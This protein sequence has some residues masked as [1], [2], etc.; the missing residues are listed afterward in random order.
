[1]KII[2]TSTIIPFVEGG[3]TFIVDW[4]EAKLKEYGHQTEVFKIPFFPF[5]KKMIPQMLSLRLLDLSA[6]S[7]KLIAIRTPSYLIKHPNKTL[8]F[9][10]HHRGAYD[11]WGTRYQDIPNTEEGIDIRNAIIKSD[12]MAFKESK[13]IYTNSKIVS[14]RL[15]KFN[16]IDSE[17]LYP[18][19]MDAEKHSCKMYGD[20]IFYPSRITSHKRQHLVMEA[21]KYV[22]SNVKLI[23]AGSPDTK[24][25]EALIKKSIRRI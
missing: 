12:N 25:D 10:H 20:Y 23:L 9:I 6:S 16:N 7:D 13:K 22:K 21:M 19:L 11:L 3:G 17:V 5:Y 14:A 2:I 8:W 4:L 24:G 1:M 15:K 18:P